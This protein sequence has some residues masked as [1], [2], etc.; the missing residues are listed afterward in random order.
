MPSHTLGNSPAKTP[1]P[2][3][4]SIPQILQLPVFCRFVPS[5]HDDRLLIW[6][7]KVANRPKHQNPA[8]YARNPPLSSIASVHWEGCA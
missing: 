4:S 1:P 6:G 5:T 8:S 3:N 7:T 2:S